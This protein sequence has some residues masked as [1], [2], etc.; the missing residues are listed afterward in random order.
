MHRLRVVLGLA[1][2]LIPAAP[3]S[4]IS[5]DLELVLAV[6][7]SGSVNPAEFALQ[8]GGYEA[9][10]R[11]P[12]VQMAIA[13]GP[14]GRVAATVV[15]W[16]GSST[17][18]MGET[19]NAIQQ[20]VPWTLIDDATDAEAFADLIAAE[21]AVLEIAV[22]MGGTV[23][24]GN[25]SDPFQGSGPTGVAR[26]LDFSRGL[27]LEDNG[28]EGMR[29]VIDISG[30][31]FENVDHDPSGCSDPPACGVG[32]LNQFLIDDP[33]L[34]FAATEAARDATLGAGITINTLSILTDFSDLDTFFYEPYVLG[35]PGSFS[36]AANDF[37]DL[38]QAV[39]D[40]I[41]TEI[42]PEPGTLLLLG[43]GLAGLAA[44]RRARA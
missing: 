27:L 12:A 16:Q 43:A 35:G 3:A 23:T 21:D 28:F 20:V 29:L 26:A 39:R 25:P 32:H 8:Q 5:V 30:D 22:G 14:L 11:D 13:N 10:F 15:Y 38:D 1:L 33:D 7:V 19:V 40:K 37:A 44:T 18:F 36:T 4:A 2:L 17:E 41:F 6:D 24:F 31:G 42:I 34:H 9:A